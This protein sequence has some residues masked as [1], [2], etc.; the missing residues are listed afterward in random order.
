MASPSAVH[1]VLQAFDSAFVLTEQATLP[2]L[3]YALD[4][5][6]ELTLTQEIPASDLSAVFYFKTDEDIN[7]L[8]Y[9][10]SHVEYYVN[11]SA[12]TGQQATLNPMNGT[13]TLNHYVAA[14]HVGKDFIRD[15]AH[16][17]FNTHFGVDLFNNEPALLQNLRTVTGVASSGQTWYDIS[18]SLVKVSTTGDH[19][20]IVTGD[21][22]GNYMTNAQTANTNI[23]KFSLYTL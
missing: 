16:Q 5:S 17:L 21:A 1:M 10:S 6:A 9:D 22:S 14:D 19:T 7:T 13:V 18:A 3:S 23:C 11:Q 12:F 4:V 20:G 2:D 8:T 15:M